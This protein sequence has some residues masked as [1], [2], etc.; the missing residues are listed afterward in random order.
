MKEGSRVINRKVFPILQISSRWFVNVTRNARAT[1]AFLR[2]PM[3]RF[4]WIPMLTILMKLIICC[5]FA[6]KTQRKLWLRILQAANF[7][8]QTMREDL[9]WQAPL[10]VTVMLCLGLHNEEPDLL[11]FPVSTISQQVRIVK[12]ALDFLGGIRIFVW[13]SFKTRVKTIWTL[14]EFQYLVNLDCK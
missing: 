5:P 9:H 10:F 13:F 1:C 14:F 8:D 12:W 4:V 2:Q 6:D 7:E 3:Q 11:D